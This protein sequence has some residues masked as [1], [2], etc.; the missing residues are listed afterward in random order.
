MTLVYNPQNHLDP[1]LQT[2]KALK[3]KLHKMESQAY[4]ELVKRPAKPNT[5]IEEDDATYSCYEL[6]KFPALHNLVKQKIQ[7][8]AY[9]H[10]ELLVEEETKEEVFNLMFFDDEEEIL[11]GC[12]LTQKQVF[13]DDTME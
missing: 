2:L 10:V 7:T 8:A 12:E 11:G 13:W 9:V 3:Y 4:T 5:L 1:L 6:T